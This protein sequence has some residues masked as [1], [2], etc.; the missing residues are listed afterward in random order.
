[1]QW[2]GNGLR[3]IVSTTFCMG[4]QVYTTK[5][6]FWLLN[7]IFVLDTVNVDIFALYIFSRYSRL[8]N[9]R[10]NVYKVKITCIMLH[11]GKHIKD[12]KINPRKIANFRKCAKI[13]T[14]ENIYVHMYSR[15]GWMKCNCVTFC[16]P[17]PP[18]THL[19]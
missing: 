10:E 11:R 6:Q 4:N 9:V 13:Y 8:S 7:P 2:G 12:A 1:M 19:K 14:R 5:I 15:S 16:A 18:H 17:P 3:V